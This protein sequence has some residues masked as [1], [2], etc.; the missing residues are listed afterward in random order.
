MM[1]LPSRNVAILQRV[2]TSKPMGVALWVSHPKPSLRMYSYTYNSHNYQPPPRISWPKR[3]LYTLAA[4]TVF[5]GYAYYMWWPKHTFPPSVAKIL[6]RGLWAESDRGENDYQLA[7]KYYIE[8]L[9]HCDEIKLDPLSDEYT[10]IQLKCGEMFERLGMGDDAAF[11]YNEVATLYLQVLTAAAGTEAARRVRDRTHRAHLIQKDLRLA[12]KLVELNRGNPQLCKAILITHLLIAQ[13]EVKKKLGGLVGISLTTSSGQ[14]LGVPGAAAEKA[15]S[16]LPTATEGVTAIINKNP[17]AW[18][19]F[20]DEFFNA[21]DLLTAICISTGDLG[22]ASKVKVSM[23]EWMMVA[24][25]E[26]HKVL[27]SQCNLASLLYLQAEEF[28]AKEI[29]L[30]RSRAKTPQT[31][32]ATEA[33]AP[34]QAS[35]GTQETSPSEPKGS[36]D[37]AITLDIHASTLGTADLAASGLSSAVAS[38]KKCIELSI[39]SYESVLEFAKTLPADVINN[40]NVVNETVALA[41]YG[42]GVVHLHLSEY[43]KAERLLREARVRSKACGYDDLIVEI[44]RELSKLFKERKQLEGPKRD[45]GSI[46]ML[47][48]LK[49]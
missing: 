25:V 36:K 41:T 48:Q 6:R 7:L 8:A 24:D 12:I 47:I 1:S 9:R 26:P 2:R 16:T 5:T 10:G 43:T 30:N 34:S 14:A 42:L 46:E 19:P 40:N 38:K 27:L 49:K 39:K 32:E 44:E 17:M 37:D 33:E 3:I 29:A 18:E 13:E 4:A 28:E 23:T 11:V 20:A 31:S 21:M 15:A 35:V 22:M 45:P